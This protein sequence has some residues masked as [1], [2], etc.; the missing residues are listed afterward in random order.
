MQPGRN[1]PFP[2]TP[3]TERPALKWPNGARVALWVVPTNEELI[4]AR[5]TVQVL[6]G[7]TTSGGVS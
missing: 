6:S 2:Y 1:G 3:I 7:K 5:Q 4:V